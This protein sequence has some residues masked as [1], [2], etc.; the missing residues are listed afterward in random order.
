MWSWNK[1][2][3]SSWYIWY[4]KAKHGSAPVCQPIHLLQEVI[5]CCFPNNQSRIPSQNV[6]DTTKQTSKDSKAVGFKET[7]LGS[8]WVTLDDLSVIIPPGPA[9][10][11]KCGIFFAQD[12]PMG[13]PILPFNSTE[14][15]WKCHAAHTLRREVYLLCKNFSM[16]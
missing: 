1:S 13:A 4:T 2:A 12:G 8:G 11:L 7:V 10:I 15:G 6:L 16:T 14:A 5:L 3:P 9:V